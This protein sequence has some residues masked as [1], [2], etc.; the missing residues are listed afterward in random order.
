MFNST[1]RVKINY[2]CKVKLYYFC[3]IL[4]ALTIKIILNVC[5]CFYIYENDSTRLSL[6]LL[7]T[8]SMKIDIN[9]EKAMIIYFVSE[10]D[11]WYCFTYIFL[12]VN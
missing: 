12:A 5:F 6:T 9:R 1:D 3:S 4:K 11:L 10:I 7:D 2:G 8:I